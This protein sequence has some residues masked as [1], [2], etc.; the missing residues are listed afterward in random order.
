[1]KEPTQIYVAGHALICT[2]NRYLAT[3]RS[4]HDGYMPGKWDI[5]GGTIEPGE[6]IEDGLIR[7][8]AEETGLSIAVV[9]PLF[10]YT[11]LSQLPRRQTFQSIFRC[12]L[13]GGELHLRLEEHDSHCWLTKD[14]L[15]HLDAIAFLEAFMNSDC[16]R[17]MV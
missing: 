14:E 6:T 3:R 9:R 13:I 7:E 11:N 1:M 16:F 4:A 17:E 8:V 10:I 5:P 12:N 15:L 2:E